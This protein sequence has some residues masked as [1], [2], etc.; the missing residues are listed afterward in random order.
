MQIYSGMQIY[1]Q[2]KFTRQCVGDSNKN[3]TNRQSSIM[4]VARESFAQSAPFI[5]VGTV[6]LLLLL[7][8]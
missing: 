5:Y 6:H 4:E 3:Q 8:A 2:S 1:K 7:M